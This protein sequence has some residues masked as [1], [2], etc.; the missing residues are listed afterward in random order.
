MSNEIVTVGAPIEERYDGVIDFA[1]EIANGAITSDG[2]DIVSGEDNFDLMMKLVGV[3]L[4]ITRVE[5]RTGISYRDDAGALRESDY[6]S[7]EITMG[8][9]GYMKFRGVD[10][11]NL[12]G[13]F[14]PSNKI[15]INDGSTGFRRNVLEH[16]VR[17][18]YVSLPDPIVTGGSKGSSSYDLPV[19]GWKEIHRGD[20]VK[21]EDGTLGYAVSF[22]PPLICPRGVRVSTYVNP[23]NTSETASTFYLG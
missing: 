14:W 17:H 23:V 1:A 13:Q 15:L 21:R 7:A 16:L 11:S 4:A 12:P 22:A 2:R 19:K 6:V 5:F 8:D 20:V 18:G 10:I 3:P 9:A